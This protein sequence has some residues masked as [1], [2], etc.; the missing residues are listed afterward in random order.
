MNIYCVNCK[1][2]YYF[3]YEYYNNIFSHDSP[4][5]PMLPREDDRA[6]KN[7]IHSA[8]CPGRNFEGTTHLIRSVIKFASRST[9]QTT[10]HIIFHVV[11]INFVK[12]TGLTF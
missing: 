7:R 1:C 9:K 11:L 8:T 12:Y 5:L 2:Y 4:L 6:S 3:Y 10:F